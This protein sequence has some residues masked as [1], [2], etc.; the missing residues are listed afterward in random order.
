MRLASWDEL[1]SGR[2]LPRHTWFCKIFLHLFTKQHDVTQVQQDETVLRH[3]TFMTV[4][5]SLKPSSS[6]LAFVKH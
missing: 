1:T 4:L 3:E 6:F 5:E 2:I